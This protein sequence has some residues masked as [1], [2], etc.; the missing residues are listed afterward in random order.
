MFVLALRQTI[1]RH[2]RLRW[3]RIK[4]LRDPMYHLGSVKRISTAYKSAAY[5]DSSDD[6]G[7]ETEIEEEDELM[8][9]D[10][11]QADGTGIVA[12]DT[13]IRTGDGTPEF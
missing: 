7:S 3:Q 13:T 8:D 1:Y 11:P 12:E 9:L 2:D 4:R 5:I 10:M 6:E